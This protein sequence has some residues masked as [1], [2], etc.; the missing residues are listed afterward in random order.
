MPTFRVTFQPGGQSASV[1]EGKSLLEAAEAAGVEIPSACGGEGICGLCKVRVTAGDSPVT[2]AEYDKLGD[3]EIK[4][5]V[6][7]A[8]QFR[9][10]SDVSCAVAGE[11]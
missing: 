11:S 4:Q 7:L 10:A 9:V 2:D 5:G 8:C 6:R 3:D 1:E